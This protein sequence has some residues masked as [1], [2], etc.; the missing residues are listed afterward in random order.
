MLEPDIATLNLINILENGKTPLKL[1]TTEKGLAIDAR[2]QIISNNNFRLTF[3]LNPEDQKR[4]ID[5]DYFFQK[6]FSLVANGIVIYVKNSSI[7]RVS[8]G[9]QEDAPCNFDIEIK[10]FKGDIEDDTWKQSRQKAYIKY[11][12]SKFN[13]Y[14]SGLIFDLKTH[15]EDNGFYNAV[16]LNVGNVDFLFYHE[17]IDTDNG[18]FIIN[19][20]GKIDFSRLEAILNAV[21]TGYGFLNGYYM[22][23]AIYYFTV[24]EIGNK[25]KVSYYYENLDAS[26][27]SDKPMMD[28]GN[29]ADIPKEQRQLTS[30]QFNKLVNLLFENKEYL[31]SAYLLIE[32][33]TLRGCAQ[34]SLG[35]VALETI[36]KKIQEI[37]KAEKIIDDKVV[38]NGLRYEL[39]KVIK[40]FSDRLDQDEQSVLTNKISNLNIKPNSNK[41]ISAFDQLGIILSQEEKECISSRNLFLHGNLPRNKNT[42]LNDHELLNIL[43]NRLVML[44]SI[45]LLKLVDYNGNVIDRGMTEVIKWRMIYA[46]QKVVGGNFLRNICKL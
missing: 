3:V 36:T 42:I 45:L 12:R 21:I 1:F 35:A 22:Y 31:R 7:I 39:N 32:A 20:N 6:P 34:A 29:Y 28:S 38:W 16:N 9:L 5:V 18:Y 17:T 19:P 4:G 41:L 44:S 43:A 10:S 46:G 37:N 14:S 33:S 13:P 25:S 11:S 24:K 15:T 30:T 26:I 2:L 23:G 27:F 40:K 8:R